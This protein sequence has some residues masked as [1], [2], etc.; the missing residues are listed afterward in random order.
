MPL[1]KYTKMIAPFTGTIILVIGCV[2]CFYGSRFLPFVI[3][4]LA[5]LGVM[6]VICLIG[7]NFLD[8]IKAEMWHLIVLMLVALVFGIIVGILIFKFAAKWG[9]TILAFWLGILLAL[10][11]LKLAQV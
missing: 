8:P 6:G 10:L 9:V 11:I 2:M 3:A 5:A 7:Y 4:F 1:E